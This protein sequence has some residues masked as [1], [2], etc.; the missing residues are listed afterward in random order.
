MCRQGPLPAA[1]PI[2]KPLGARPLHPILAPFGGRPPPFGGR[3]PPI[4]SPPLRS[5]SIR[6]PRNSSECTAN[7]P[8]KQPSRSFSPN[9]WTGGE[10]WATTRTRTE[11][12]APSLPRLA[13]T[14]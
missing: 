6:G 7:E 14:L 1:R 3:H 11:R 10:S 5:V 12:N 9:P 8:A 4:S 2:P 13:Q